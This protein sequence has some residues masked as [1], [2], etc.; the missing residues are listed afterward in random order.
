MLSP[1]AMHRQGTSSSASPSRKNKWS[2]PVDKVNPPSNHY[3][4]LF[5]SVLF[6][7]G[8]LFLLGIALLMGVTAL[9][10]LFTGTEVRAEQTVP[11]VAFGFEAIVLLA[12]A[13]FSLQKF[14]QKPTADEK[15]SVSISIWQIILLIFVAGISLL[16]G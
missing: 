7:L 14:L 2:N 9:V 11:L 13:F 12:A 16:I 8:A 5:S 4:S 10:S 6:I 3:P 15:A 1:A